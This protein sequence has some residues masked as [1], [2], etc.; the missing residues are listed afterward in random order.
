MNR[1]NALLT[2]HPEADVEGMIDVFFRLIDSGQLSPKSDE[3]WKDFLYNKGKLYKIFSQS[4]ERAAPT[5]D[6]SELQKFRERLNR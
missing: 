4:S 3:L 6:K 1:L 5:D 2:E